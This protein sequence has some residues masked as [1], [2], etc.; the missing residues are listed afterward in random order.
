M[1][2][3]YAQAHVLH[4][5]DKWTRRDLNPKSPPFMNLYARAA[6]YQIMQQAQSDIH[7]DSGYMELRM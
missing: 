5:L 3:A 4:E 1:G 2:F 7:F 6:Q